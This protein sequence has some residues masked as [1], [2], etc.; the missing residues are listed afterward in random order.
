MRDTRRRPYS[1]GSPHAHARCSSA[2]AAQVP[3]DFGYGQSIDFAG[4]F[5]LLVL[6]VKAAALLPA[7]IIVP[8]VP[9]PAAATAAAD[10]ADDLAAVRAFV[11]TA[12]LQPCAVAPDTPGS[13]AMEEAIRSARAAGADTPMLHTVANLCRLMAVSM[14]CEQVTPSAVA[15]V[16]EL[17]AARRARSPPRTRAEIQAAAAA[18]TASKRA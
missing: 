18:T 8:Y 16:V 6:S 14:G 9:A 11:G 2:H 3:Y 13:T 17:E 4:D 1:C 7:D 15:R 5:P 12:R 10:A